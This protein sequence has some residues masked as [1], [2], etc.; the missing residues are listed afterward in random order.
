MALEASS[1]DHLVGMSSGTEGVRVP[2]AGLRGGLHG[3]IGDGLTR[4]SSLLHSTM[5]IAIV[6]LVIIGVTALVVWLLDKSPNQ[7]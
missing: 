7:E 6:L 5:T 1:R 2:M 4:S 3:A